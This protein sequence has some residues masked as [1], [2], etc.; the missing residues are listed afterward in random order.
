MLQND[1]TQQTQHFFSDSI[2]KTAAKPFRFHDVETRDSTEDPV[3]V[4]QRL[5][6]FTSHLLKPHSRSA[7]PFNAFTLDWF[8]I[9]LL[10]MLVLLT[11]FKV[12]YIRIFSQLWDAFFSLTTTN[13]I[14]RDESVL[15]QRASL[16]LSIIAY[17]VS[18]LFLYQVSVVMGWNHYLLPGGFNRFI[19][20]AL[21]I[22]LAY[23]IKMILLRFLSVVFKIEKPVATY[24]F[25]IFLVNMVIGLF[26]FPA[27]IL[28]AYLPAEY[29]YYIV[30]GTL[31][32]LASLLLYRLF[33]AVGIG[34]SIQRFSLFYLF[35][36]ICSFEIAPLL[37]IYKLATL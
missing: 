25:N 5:E 12:F 7:E 21:I 2:V 26:L 35:L 36:Y 13:Q 16:I 19:L 18:G 23:S 9:V 4:P 10:G 24:I 17:F 11:W 33:R 1:S 14:V 8:T 6:L 22:A 37:I 15:L 34:L 31:V 30:T 32:I 28:I 29:R 27:I 3:V 20:F